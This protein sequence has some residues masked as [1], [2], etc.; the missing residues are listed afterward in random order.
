ML[1]PGQKVTIRFNPHHSRL[2]GV[3]GTVVA[4]QPKRGFGGCDLALV[5]YRHPRSGRTC[6]LPF[7]LALLEPVGSTMAPT[8]D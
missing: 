1:K 2:K 7:A 8:A 4:I 6:A 3:L 5:R